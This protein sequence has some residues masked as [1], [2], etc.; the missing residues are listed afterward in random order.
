MLERLKYLRLLACCGPV[1]LAIFIVCWGLM[2]HNMPPFQPDVSAQIIGEY[3]RNDAN[4]IR[5]GM[6]MP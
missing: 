6:G 3:F 5:L 1:F 2:G 4:M